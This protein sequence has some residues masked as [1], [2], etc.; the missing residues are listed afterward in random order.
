MTRP[1]DRELKGASSAGLTG[2]EN[3]PENGGA[4]RVNNITWLMAA[5]ILGHVDCWHTGI[6]QRA[7]GA[8]KEYKNSVQLLK[9]RL[10][11]WIPYWTQSLPMRLPHIPNAA[12]VSHAS[13]TQLHHY[14]MF[15]YMHTYTS[16]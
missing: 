14:A 15:T 2:L 13:D 16:T 8:C 11:Y 6:V 12:I 5:W 3:L 4:E 9:L 10:Q 7:L 1:Q